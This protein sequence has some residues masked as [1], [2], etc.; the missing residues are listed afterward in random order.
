M[1]YNVGIT[2]YSGVLGKKFIKIFKKKINFYPFKG[3]INYKSHI[4]KWVNN[5]NFDFLIHLAAIVPTKLVNRNKN[6]SLQ[7]NFY[8]TVNLLDSIKNKKLWFFFASTSHVYKKTNYKLTENCTTIPSSYYGKTKLLTEKF[9]A[10][11][12]KK[13]PNISFCIG[14]IFSF[15][16]SSQCHSFLIPS[17]VKKIIKYKNNNRKI[18]ILKDSNI[19]RD[20]V[21]IE[22]ICFAIFILMKKN[23]KGIFNIASG[24]NISLKKIFLTIKKKIQFKKKVLFMN[25]KRDDTLVASINKLRRYGWRNHN[26]F[27]KI[28]FQ[29]LANK[30]ELIF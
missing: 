25:K 22:D 30:R 6:K 4:K 23:C 7:T 11:Y 17:L 24:K 18:F 15:T 1:K 3:N 10:K 19:E 2:G 27:E 16:D 21:S 5:N 29:Y 13:N 9:I 8:G 20:F 26:S 14:R 28:V 12:S